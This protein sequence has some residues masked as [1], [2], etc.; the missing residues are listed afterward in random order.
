MKKETQTKD[1][2]RKFLQQ[3]TLGAAAL[4]GAPFLA[5]AGEMHSESMA[6]DLTILFQG[7]SITDAGRDRGQYYANNLNGMGKGYV[8]QTAAHLLGENPGKGL[9]IYNR[10]ISGHKV[11][12]LANRWEDDCLNLKPDVLSILIG[13]NDFWHMLNGRYDGTAAVYD[14][15]FRKLLERTKKALPNVKLIICEPFV[16]KGGSA[17]GDQRWQNEFPLY[18]NSAK[19]IASDF[20]AAFVPFQWVF[21]KALE[22]E[23]AAYWCP[24]GVH[25]S[26][27]GAHLMKKAW[28]EAYAKL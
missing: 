17:V 20:G 21:D 5:T 8:Y 6:D 18:R 24:D 3:A 4:M 9:R 11:F 28:L 7:D 16:V 12:Q 2:R 27:A 25:P 14:A 13:V 19:Q 23:S 15:D 22:K 1:G 10:G 26:I